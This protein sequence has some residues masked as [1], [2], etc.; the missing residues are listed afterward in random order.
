MASRAVV[1]PAPLGPMS[2]VIVPG[3][4]S[5]SRPATTSVAPNRTREAADLKGHRRLQPG[6]AAGGEDGDDHEA[7]PAD[8][9]L[10]AAEVE[11]GE[12]HAAG[13]QQPADHGAG[14]AGDAA[15]VGHG[16]VG[17]RHEHPERAERQLALLV[18]EQGAGHAGQEGRQGEGAE[19]GGGDVDPTAAAARSLARTARSR[20]P[21]PAVRSRA[22][23]TAVTTSTASTRSPKAAPEGSRPAGAGT[24][25]PPKPPVSVGR[26]NTASSTTTA[27]ARVTTARLTPRAR[28]AGRPTSRP[29]PAASTAASSGR[30][31][32]RHADLGGQPAEGEAGHAGEGHL[33]QGDLAGPT[34]EDDDRQAHQ[35]PDQ[36][37]DH[38]H[39][40]LAGEARARRQRRPPC[41]PRPTPPPGGGEGR[42]AAAGRRRR[43]RPGP[44]ARRRR[45]A[46]A[47]T[48]T[49]RGTA[50]RT[51]E[52]GIHD[53]LSWA[54][55]SSDWVMPRARPAATVAPKDRSRPTRAAASAGTTSRVVV[56]GSSPVTG[57][58]RMP[59]GAGQHAGRHPVDGG[60]DVGRPAE[61][62]HAG[63]VVR[64]GPAGQAE[65]GEA[66]DGPQH[67]AGG[68]PRWRP[69]A[70]GRAAPRPRTPA[71][72]RPA[73]SPAPAAR[74]SKRRTIRACSVAMRPTDAT[75]PASAGAVRRGRN[76]Q[77][78]GDQP[79]RRRQR[80]GSRRT[81][82]PN[83]TS[84]PRC[85][86][87]TGRT[88]SPAVRS[89]TNT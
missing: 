14:D 83:G 47:T 74:R 67:D 10:V 3:A 81:P 86:R 70:A 79:D 41:R 48:M 73:G 84:S 60:Q 40:V 75:S 80:G 35:H 54:S 49:T 88:R 37:R 58:T 45:A 85:T 6:D 62:G 1:L 13:D 34:G 2:P 38:R 55:S 39:A 87:P 59:R 12:D 43:R 89:S 57:A 7:E 71:P 76:T 46:R 27:P 65:P 53:Q 20:R 5:R 18:A 52:R 56:T 29:A 44:A 77:Q 66:V 51:P 63:H 42:G 4:R 24:R 16:Q 28:S 33:G 30:D 21:A 11:Q 69:A 78:V 9:Q 23:P 26:L 50:S 82:A 15:Q 19:A 22:S 8:Q 32:E 36:R 64:R 72:G 17:Q 61:E 68:R 31:R 25:E